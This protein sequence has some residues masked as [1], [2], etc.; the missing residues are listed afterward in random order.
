MEKVRRMRMRRTAVTLLT[1][2]LLMAIAP[3]ATASTTYDPRGEW[4]L[5]GT[6]SCNYPVS[7]TAS[8]TQM[9]FAT[10]M[11]SGTVTIDGLSGPLSGSIT[12]NQV[13]ITSTVVYQEKTSYFSEVGTIAADGNSMS[14]SWMTT[15]AVSWTGTLTATRIP[16][17]P[18]SPPSGPSGGGSGSGGSGSGQTG[19]GQ[20]G[21]GQ[22]T[23]S[24]TP[25][26]APGSVSQNTT[27]GNFKVLPA[28]LVGLRLLV[29]ANGLV[30]VRLANANGFP[31]TG[32]LTLTDA[33]IARAAKYARKTY[34]WLGATR[35]AISSHAAKT[36]SLRLSQQGRAAL[37]GGLLRAVLTITTT[38]RGRSAVTRTYRVRLAFATRAASRP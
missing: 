16:P 34:L 7:G 29:S 11:F 36:V 18:P 37:A 32:T 13:S 9:D 24:G 19:T 4:Q 27:G 15:G 22:T 20:T 14:G 6:C 35:F 33:K 17:P 31:I 25:A 1:S 10:G 12:G 3:A 38:A 8:I 30:S 2:A 23:G 26:T 21:A 28:R 5:T